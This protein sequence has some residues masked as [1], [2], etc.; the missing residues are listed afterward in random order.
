MRQNS[1]LSFTKNDW[2]FWCTTYFCFPVLIQKQNKT[3]LSFWKKKM[4]DTFGKAWVF[5]LQFSFLTKIHKIHKYIPQDIYLQ[6]IKFQH[7]SAFKRVVYTKKGSSTKRIF[8]LV[9]SMFL[10]KIQNLNFRSLS[11]EGCFLQ[12]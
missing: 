2:P 3:F 9:F 1:N 12:M 8:L 4:N 10:L 7:D 5:K 11:P 6:N